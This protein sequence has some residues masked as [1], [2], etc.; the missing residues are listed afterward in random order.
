MSLHAQLPDV[1][2][3]NLADS[4]DWTAGRL[5]LAMPVVPVT[6]TCAEV[7]EWFNRR[8]LQVAAAI[9]DELNGVV[10][11]ANRLRFFARYAQPYHPELY[12]KR[13]IT[14]LGNTNPLIVD[15]H[16]AVTELASMIT[17]DWP[18]SLREC[19]VVTREG[20]YFGI[21]TSEALVRCK[22]EILQAREAQLKS[23]VLSAH[24]ASRAKSTFLALMSHE[25]RTPLN[26]I[27]GFSEVLSTE[28]LGPIGSQ[29]YREY[30]TD[31]HGAGNHLLALIND[32]LDLSKAEA[33]KLD[34]YP[35]PVDV[36]AAFRDCI[37]LVAR[38]A[39]QQGLQLVVEAPEDLPMLLADAL[40]L[41]QILLNL[42][43]NAIKFTPSGGQIEARAELGPE[44]TFLIS[45]R[46]TGIGMAPEMIPAAFEAFRQVGAA[47]GRTMEGT[48]LGLSLVKLLTEQHGGE[49]SIQSAL[50]KGTNVVLRFPSSR[51]L[52][53]QDRIRA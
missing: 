24:T 34:L 7:F 27:I 14:S 3:D 45:I 32:I 48:G 11:I 19:F 5:A 41:K 15:E 28:L 13:S 17:I 18:D 46:D 44:N 8:P 35:E 33:G 22:L 38:R 37:K 6:M 49:V 25:L 47:S 40:R 2:H 12:G 9:V 43:S 16:V 29:R 53:Q 21:G 4:L 30:A 39:A 36:P 23:A 42:L 51:T 31:I 26:A 1:R 50:D 20:R 52:F 10:G